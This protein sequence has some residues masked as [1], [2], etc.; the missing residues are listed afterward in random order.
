MSINRE[1]GANTQTES[2]TGL[3]SGTP[4]ESG[5]DKKKLN[6]AVILMAA[7]LDMA[8]SFLDSGSRVANE[9]NPTQYNPPARG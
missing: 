5:V 9:L 8:C 4:E 1:D 3:K 7:A 2:C 6:L